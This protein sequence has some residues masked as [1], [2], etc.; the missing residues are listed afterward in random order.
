[1]LAITDIR[2]IGIFNLGILHGLPE[3]LESQFP[4]G[5]GITADKGALSHAYNRN[6]SHNCSPVIVNVM[7]LYILA[8]IDLYYFAGDVPGLVGG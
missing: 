6:F 2:D 3:S 7:S 4:D 1:M 8:A 5:T